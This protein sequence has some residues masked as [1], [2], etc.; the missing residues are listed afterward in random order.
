MRYIKRFLCCYIFCLFSG[1]ALLVPFQKTYATTDQRQKT[2]TATASDWVSQD[3]IRSRLIHLADHDQDDLSETG[4]LHI[5]LAEGWKIYW[6]SPGE[7]GT[8]PKLD[9]QKSQNLSDIIFSWPVPDRFTLF[10]I[11]TYGYANQVFF[12]INWI[13]QQQG[14][15][16]LALSLS[17]LACKEI[18]VPLSVSLTFQPD[19]ARRPLSD[20]DLQNY[21]HFLERIPS[22]TSVNSKAYPTPKTLTLSTFLWSKDPDKHPDKDQDTPIYPVTLSFTAPYA[23]TNPDILLE[24]AEQWTYSIPT[25]TVS[26]DQKTAFLS[27]FISPL[28]QNSVR[29]MNKLLTL[30]LIDRQEKAV[31]AVEDSFKLAANGTSLTDLDGRAIPPAKFA[32]SHNSSFSLTVLTM[33]AIA[34]IGGFI[35]NM[36]PCVLPVLSLKI[37]HFLSQAGVEKRKMRHSF[38]MS[39]AGIIFSFW[40]LAAATI[41]L[42]VIGA[43]IGWGIQFQYPPFLIFLIIVLLAFALNLFGLY[44]IILPARLN[45]LIDRLISKQHSN[46]HRSAFLNGALTTLLATPCSAPFV[47]T[48]ISFALSHSIIS[49]FMIFTCLG[50][51]LATPYFLIAVFPGATQF[52]PKPD[53]WMLKVKYG[54]GIMLCLTAAWLSLILGTPGLFSDAIQSENRLSWHTFD[55]EALPS[56]ITDGKTVL[57]DITADWCLTCKINEKI[58]FDNQEVIERLSDDTLYLM[59]GDWTR[60]DPRISAFLRE[61]RHY[62]I[63]FNILFKPEGDYIIL[64]E[65]LYPSDLLSHLPPSE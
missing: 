65:L 2:I 28:Y 22:Q 53:K 46:H 50:I 26:A 15:L 49:I 55:P 62:G 12:P 58:A 40:C 59:R 17:I 21:A 45:S 37:L 19:T 60:P 57:V 8:P 47:G 52:L 38:L 31:F 36:M 29:P 7:A 56:L 61:Y 32:S 16:E 13:K 20:A 39:C 30:T 54:M 6:R 27:F 42:K 1:F 43:E 64:P 10:G 35:L 48:A 51:G 34:L 23:L 9:W 3:F 25:S 63:P 44:Q 33:M 18:C 5:E 11:T 41:I 14:P 4:A 24:G